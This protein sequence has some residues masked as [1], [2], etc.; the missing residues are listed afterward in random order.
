MINM[1]NIKREFDML[2]KEERDKAIKDIIS[3]YTIERDEEMDIIGAG[4]IL[5]NFLQDIAPKV[6]NKAIEDAKK[7]FKLKS[8]EV[9]FELDVFK[10]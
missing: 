5:D 4:E 2:T 3:F 1:K 10:K 9:D 7:L 8:E 6:Y